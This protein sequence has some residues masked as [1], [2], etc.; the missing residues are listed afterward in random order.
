MPIL[1]VFC[2]ALLFLLRLR[3]SPGTSVART[4]G[5]NCLPCAQVYIMFFIDKM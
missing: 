5:S 3:F 4:L 1:R 2:R